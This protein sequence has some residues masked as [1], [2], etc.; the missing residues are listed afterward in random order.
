MARTSVAGSALSL[1]S[2]FIM[3]AIY[4]HLPTLKA[5]VAI[6]QFQA[7]YIN[8]SGELA[9]ATASIPGD[10][11]ADRDADP[12]ATNP[13]DQRCALIPF[14]GS[15]C[16]SGIAASAIAVGAPVYFAAAGKMD[17]AGTLRAGTAIT[18]TSATGQKIDYVLKVPFFNPAAFVAV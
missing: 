14:A 8:S 13:M 5:A 2:Q 1:E 12:A 7:V 9:L 15:S 4:E 11:Y 16:A 6:T 18:A 10:G 3:A 17:D